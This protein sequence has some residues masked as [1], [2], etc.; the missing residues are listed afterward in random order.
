METL[1]PLL[2]NVTSE[3]R[4]ADHRFNP[5]IAQLYSK[6]W[7]ASFL[8]KTLASQPEQSWLCTKAEVGAPVDNLEDALAVIDE[9]RRRGHHKIIVKESLGLAGHN[10]IRLWEPSLLETQ[11][12]WMARALGHGKLVIEP[13]LERLADFSIQLEMNSRGLKVCGYTGLINDLRGQF[14][15]NCAA[16]NHARRIPLGVI[17][18]FRSLP[19]AVEGIE[20]FYRDILASLEADLDSAGYLGPLGIDALVYRS[21]SGET[22][23]KPIVEINPRF[24]MGRLTVELMRQV[25]PGSYGLFRLINHAVVRKEG[26]ETFSEYARSMTNRFPVCLEGAPTP[27]IRT[28][29]LCLNDP[30]RAQTCLATFQVSRTSDLF[31]KAAL[32]A[33]AH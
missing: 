15:A 4:A 3:N 26:F 19:A 9:I 22:R 16:A 6:V 5:A 21:F 32:S 12:S 24:T 23:L 28:G 8:K 14:Q 2:G 29:M 20:R 18:L 17:S 27:R 31:E 10:S 33:S 11:R 13:W 7:S 30:N 25:C 1:G